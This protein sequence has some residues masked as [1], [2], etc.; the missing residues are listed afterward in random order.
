MS[1][2]I[3]VSPPTTKNPSQPKYR[4]RETIT[5]HPIPICSRVVSGKLDC[6]TT[7]N[8]ARAVA[9]VDLLCDERFCWGNKHNLSLRKPAIDWKKLDFVSQEEP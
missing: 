6:V 3:S 7:R 1:Y 2:K 8:A 5:D 4:L 9:R